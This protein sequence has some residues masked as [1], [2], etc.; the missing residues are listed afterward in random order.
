VKKTILTFFY[1]CLFFPLFVF[2]DVPFTASCRAG[3][4]YVIFKDTNSFKVYIR[5][6]DIEGNRKTKEQIILRSLIFAPGDSVLLSQLMSELEA[7][8]NQLINTGLFYDVTMNLK[9][10]EG[11]SLDIYITVVE[12]WYTYPLPTLDLYDRNFN[13][14][15]VENNHDINR[16]QYGV[17]FVQQNVRGRN[18]DLH[19]T[20]LLGFAQKFEL[21]YHVPYFDKKQKNGLALYG[22]FGQSKILAI[23]TENNKQKFYENEKDFARRNW[24][25]ELNWIH[26]PRF[27]YKNVFSVSYNEAYI[28]DTI[29]RVSP[30]YFLNG[31]KEERFVALTY[32]LSRDYLDIRAYP[33]KGSY[34]EVMAAKSGIGLFNNNV[35]MSALTVTYNK[36]IPLGKGFYF[37]SQNKV[38]YS[39]PEKQPYYNQKALGYRNDYV[40]GYEYYVIDGQQFALTKMNLRYQLFKMKMPNP[41][42]KGMVKTDKFPFTFFLKAQV[43]A[44]YVNDDYYLR[45]NPMN[46]SL[47]VGYGP[48]IDILLFHDISSRIEYSWNRMGEGGLYLHVSSFLW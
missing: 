23:Q 20:A 30:E 16:I 2:A 46:N 7:S 14:W 36:Y 9:N 22:S 45:N 6:I 26:Q 48:G 29:A 31:K 33:L 32:T 12:R 43:S 13:N 11:K 3:A 40:C 21:L 38:K 37:S 28:S 25:V 17:R 5:S 39:L 47:L 19:V 10:W 4:E 41:W 18:E 27:H 15:W 8:R 34:F 24:N 42:K 35:D 1:S 44:A